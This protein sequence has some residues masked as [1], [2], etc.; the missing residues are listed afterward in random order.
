MVAALPVGAFLPE[1]DVAGEVASD[2]SDDAVQQAMQRLPALGI[3]REGA[4]AGFPKL[5]RQKQRLRPTA[6]ALGVHVTSI[7]TAL[8]SEEPRV[9]FRRN[10]HHAVLGQRQALRLHPDAMCR[11]E[12][13]DEIHPD[14]KANRVRSGSVK[15]H[16][17]QHRFGVPEKAFTGPAVSPSG[18]SE[19]NG[20]QS[21]LVR[22]RQCEMI[23]PIEQQR[24][25]ASEHPVGEALGEGVAGEERVDAFQ[26]EV[27]RI[28]T[29]RPVEFLFSG[30]HKFQTESPAPAAGRVRVVDRVG[31]AAHVGLPGVAAAFAAAAGFL[32]A[33]EGAA[34]LR[35]AGADVHVGDAAIAAA[36]ARGTARPRAGRW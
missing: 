21:R 9:L 24:A 13:R 3:A 5:V 29:E 11:H 20:S 36:R 27:F 8:H 31:L 6:F 10:H 32:F 28:V 16:A 17:R 30:G 2:E 23:D 7:A 15:L 25:R 12:V 1:H 35:A 34:D 33:A 26:Q 4:S 14:G 22:R 18:F 19:T